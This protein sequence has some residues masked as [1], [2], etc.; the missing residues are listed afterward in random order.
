MKSSLPKAL[1]ENQCLTEQLVADANLPKKC[2]I[3]PFLMQKVWS[4]FFKLEV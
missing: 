3:G 2:F 4:I 1:P